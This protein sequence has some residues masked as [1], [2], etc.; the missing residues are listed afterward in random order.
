MRETED[1][2]SDTEQERETEDDDSDTESW[3]GKQ[4]MMTQ[5]QRA[6]EGNRR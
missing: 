3:R 1:D 4:K 6:G 2:D 5:I